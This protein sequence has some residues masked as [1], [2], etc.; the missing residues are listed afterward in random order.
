MLR[1][2]SVDAVGI[3]FGEGVHP[4]LSFAGSSWMVGITS[5]WYFEFFALLLICGGYG[6][7]CVMDSRRVRIDSHI[8]FFL[9]FATAEEVA[10][11]RY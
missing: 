7:L 8:D 5:G 4:D 11:E 3:T 9:R 10:I 2:G 1:P 6:W